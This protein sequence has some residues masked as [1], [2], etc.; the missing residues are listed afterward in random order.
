MAAKTMTKSVSTKRKR[1]ESVSA[2]KIRV[3][4][5]ESARKEVDDGRSSGE[6]DDEDEED[7]DEDEDEEE[8]DAAEIFRRHFEARF[9]PLP[10]VKEKKGGKKS[11]VVA[12]EEDDDEDEDE[13]WGGL[14]EEIGDDDEEE[15]SDDDEGVKRRKI[16]VVEHTSAASAP[17]MSK[18]ELKAFMS[19]RPPS[20]TTTPTALTTPTATDPSDKDNTANDLALHRLLTES[21]LLTSTTSSSSHQTH[22]L[23]GTNRHRATDLRIQALGG[24][25]SLFVQAKMPMHMRK[26]IAA[27]AEER[28]KGRRE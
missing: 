19:A 20:S 25:G 18:A 12:E 23:E 2:R 7:E 10:D 9:K 27:K 21:H 26:G 15:D 13:E 8:L 16:D 6:D 24:K 1:E 11:G 17:K 14:S 5:E 28:E 22:T 4:E 3:L